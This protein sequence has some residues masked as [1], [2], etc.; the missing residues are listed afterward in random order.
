MELEVFLR[1]A[2]SAGDWGTGFVG[3]SG[4]ECGCGFVWRYGGCL[5]VV[6]RSDF[7]EDDLS[8]VREARLRIFN[9]S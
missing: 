9:V 3:R 4:E 8:D 5:C 1:K 2:W 7:E 6:R